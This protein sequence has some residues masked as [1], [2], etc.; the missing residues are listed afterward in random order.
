MKNIEEPI[1][2]TL[3]KMVEKG[4]LEEEWDEKIKGFRYKVS[5]KGIKEFR[6]RIRTSP[7]YALYY[8]YVWLT[9]Q[10]NKDFWA[11][12]REFTVHMMKDY[13]I[14]FIPIFFYSVEKGW[15][16]GIEIKEPLKSEC[17]ELIKL[18]QRE[19]MK[20]ARMEVKK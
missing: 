17:K 11:V 15:I 4:L 1:N 10:K 8:F 16:K 5:E 20:L 14:N 3:R 12:F 2:L 7:T 18:N 6:R 9:F 19:L 13:K